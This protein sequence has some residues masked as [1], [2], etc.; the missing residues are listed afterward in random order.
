[1]FLPEGK[2]TSGILLTWKDFKPRFCDHQPFHSVRI[3]VLE[4]QK[5]GL[6]C[7]FSRQNVSL[8]QAKAV[9]AI[10]LLRLKG[11]ISWSHF[12]CAWCPLGHLRFGKASQP[13]S[14]SLLSIVS[15]PTVPCGPQWSLRSEDLASYYPQLLCYCPGPL[16]CWVFCFVLFFTVLDAPDNCLSFLS[17]LAIHGRDFVSILCNSSGCFGI[18]FQDVKF[19]IVQK[20]KDL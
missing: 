3:Q 9:L 17:C 18:G 6:P 10:P 14:F 5:P 16:G 15:T 19:S 4:L 11:F 1:M 2:Q 12:L 7:Q 13:N 8:V 20:T